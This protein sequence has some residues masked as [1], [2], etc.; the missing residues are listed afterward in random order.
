MDTLLIQ[1]TS[2]K[3]EKADKGF[4]RFINYKSTKQK[5]SQRKIA[6]Q[7]QGIFKSYR[8]RV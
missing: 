6:R 5:C 1:L 8:E 2:K 3:T 4:R 7:I